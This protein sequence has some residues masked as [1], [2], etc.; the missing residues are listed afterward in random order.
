MLVFTGGESWLEESVQSAW[1]SCAALDVISIHAYGTGDLS[2]SALQPYV[3]KA[4]AAGKKLIMEE[5][6]VATLPLSATVNAERP[7][8]G[9][10]ATLI[11]RT[12][13]ARAAPFSRRPLAMRTS[14]PGHRR[15]RRPAYLGFTGRSS[16][17]RTLT[18]VLSPARAWRSADHAHST[19]TTMRSASTMR[20][21]P[22]SRQPL[23]R[24]RARR[25]R[26]TSPSTCCKPVAT[27][28]A[29]TH[30]SE[31]FGRILAGRQGK[32]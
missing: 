26:S 1:L 23:R 28:C 10:H 21:G 30:C 2:A 27:T 18:Y 12:T 22:R 8:A 15:S 29:H 31:P 20:P 16:R 14:K 32:H 7:R 24:P 6:C 19:R 4:Q 5:W 25:R 3:Q 17:M 9:A 11:H 13:T